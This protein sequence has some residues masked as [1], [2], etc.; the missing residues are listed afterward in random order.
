MRSGKRRFAS[1]LAKLFRDPAAFALDLPN[2][3]L[4][5]LTRI[6]LMVVMAISDLLDFRSHAAALVW[7]IKGRP[8]YLWPRRLLIAPVTEAALIARNQSGGVL[9]GDVATPDRPLILK[10]DYR[11]VELVAYG[12]ESVEPP[13]VRLAPVSALGV[14]RRA[15]QQG[16]RLDDALRRAWPGRPLVA[17]RSSRAE[18]AAWLAQRLTGNPALGHRG[19]PSRLVSI[20]LPVRDPDLAHLKVALDSV[21]A[22][23]HAAWQLCIADDGS[24]SGPVKQ[25]LA[26]TARDP[27]VRLVTLDPPRGI[28]GATNAALDLATGSVAV[29]MDHDDELTPEA[30]QRL[31]EAFEHQEVE[32]VYSDEAVMDGAGRLT[33]ATLKPAFDPERLLAQN[34]VNHLFAVRTERLRRIGGL[35]PS[36]DGAQDHDLVLRLSEQLPV[37]AI[38]HLPEVLYHWRRVRGGGSFS[39]KSANRAAAARRGLVEAHLNRL[40]ARAGVEA[41]PLGFNRIR[42][43]LRDRPKVSVIIPSRDRPDL[44]RACIAGLQLHTDYPDLEILIVDNGSVLPEAVALLDQLRRF[45]AISVL[46]EPGPFNHSRLNNR[47]VAAT[48][49]PILALL[50]DDILVSD[51]DWL[52]EMVSLAV[53]PSVG[54]VGARLL[55]PDGRIQHAGVV[56]GL[57]PHGIAGHELRGFAGDATGPQYRL[58]T[59]RRTSAVTAACLVV[60]RAKFEA[61]GGFDEAAFPIAFNDVDLCLRLSAAGYDSVWTPFSRLIHRESASRGKTLDA[62]FLE[63]V[64]QMRQ[65]WGGQ[66]RDDRYSHPQLSR[67]D[68]TLSLA[69]VRQGQGR[70]R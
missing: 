49:A 29:F 2:P 45:P 5:G 21:L 1:R 8:G 24:R 63:A 36:F 61:V 25:L 26:E 44:L 12:I 17:P 4:R 18:Q 7:R 28:S 20:L 30:V 10:A 62:A 58:V 15:L 42:W 19:H 38:R 9:A 54:A 31:V 59:T 67:Q 64:A 48:Q 22:Q 39:Q 47:G 6:D 3:F 56:L 13:S 33:A 37:G 41:G 43:S 50:N 27:R 11:A 46:S 16:A 60:E 52:S 55:Y 23:T 35:D 53:R 51:R 34:Y 70:L 65:R 40:G 69:A 57:G 14:V 68:E 32:A 66:L